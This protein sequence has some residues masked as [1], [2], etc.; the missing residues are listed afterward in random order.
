MLI[1]VSIGCLI[2]NCSSWTGYHTSE[3]YGW[4]QLEA[5]HR[6][7]FGAWL[8][9]KLFPL[10]LA[11]Q[12]VGTEGQWLHSSR[13]PWRGLHRCDFTSEGWFQHFGAWSCGLWPTWGRCFCRV[14]CTR[15]LWGVHCCSSCSRC[16]RLRQAAG[17]GATDTLAKRWPQGHA[18]AARAS[19]LSQGKRQRA[20]GADGNGAVHGADPH[21]WGVRFSLGAI[22]AELVAVSS[23]NKAT[24][25]TALMVG[26][27][28]GPHVW[29]L[30]GL[31]GLR[32]MRAAF[33]GFTIKPDIVFCKCVAVLLGIIGRPP[34][35]D[36]TIPDWFSS[37]VLLSIFECSMVCF[38]MCFGSF[39]QLFVVLLEI[40]KGPKGSEGYRAIASMVT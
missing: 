38:S 4:L 1:K 13:T 11:L 8:L 18:D 31:R 16:S 33:L 40:R 28:F 3:V 2:R 5:L 27:K 19:I 30:V 34:Y 29:R 26:R 23:S 32:L 22:L 7:R 10:P 39:A 14:H 21:T 37:G 25:T 35:C 12:G 36:H 17:Q 24:T 9:P 6:S 20:S 15:V